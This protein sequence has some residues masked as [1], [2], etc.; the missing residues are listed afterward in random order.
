MQLPKIA[1]YDRFPTT[2]ALVDYLRRPDSGKRR[3]W[4]TRRLLITA[5]RDLLVCEDSAEFLDLLS[6]P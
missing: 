6:H 2:S 3:E 4:L 1:A 5:E